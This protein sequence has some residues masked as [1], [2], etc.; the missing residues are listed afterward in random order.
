MR[1]RSKHEIYTS[2]K[3]NVKV[4]VASI[5]LIIVCQISL[6]FSACDVTW[7]PNNFQTLEHFTPQIFKLYQESLEKENQ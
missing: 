2:C 4:I 6:E 7:T 5:F 3:H 1:P